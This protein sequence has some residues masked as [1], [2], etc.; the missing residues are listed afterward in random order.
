MNVIN[1]QC[2][3]YDVDIKNNKYLV[4]IFD[5]CFPGKIECCLAFDVNRGLQSEFRLK[6]HETRRGH[7]ILMNEIASRAGLPYL[8]GFFDQ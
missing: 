3:F 8:K 6:F 4:S 2:K 1:Q 7:E 5:T